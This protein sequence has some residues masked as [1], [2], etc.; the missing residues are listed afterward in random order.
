MDSL[1]PELLYR[2]CTLVAIGEERLA[3]YATISRAWQRMIEDRTFSH[4]SLVNDELHFFE[5]AVVNS[6]YKHRRMDIRRVDLSINL[7]S[8]DDHS[9]GR[10]ERQA[11]RNINDTAFSKAVTQLFGALASIDTGDRSGLID[12]HLQRFDSPMDPG[13]RGSEKLSADRLAMGIGH[14]KDLFELRYRD[15]YLQ[16]LKPENLPRLYNVASLTINGDNERKLAPSTVVGLISR[17][18][19]LLNVNC[20][21]WDNERRRPDQRR[22][23][24][25][26]LSEQLTTIPAPK[27]LKRFNMT[28]V[29]R[30][31]CNSN[32]L[33]ADIRGGIYA[34]N[35]DDLSNGLRL[36]SKAAPCLTNFILSGPIS[37]GPDIFRPLD[38]RSSDIEKCWEHLESFTIK[39]SAVRPDGGW[40]I[41]RAPQRDT[42]SSD[43]EG[44]DEEEEA[45]QED[46]DHHGTYSEDSLS[47][48]DSSDS[49]F[50]MDQLPPDSYGYEDERR[51]E[52]LNG[53]R[54]STSNF[55][56]KPTGELETLFL[57][58]ADAASRMPMLRYMS[59]SLE[60]RPSGRT[61]RRFR[62]L[63]FQYQAAKCPSN[64]FGGKGVPHLQ[65][66]VPRG[67]RMDE[68]LE[69]QWLL[70]LG[71]DGKVR[72][73]EW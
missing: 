45:E 55:R 35:A 7:P 40:Y 41:E 64:G 72:Y 43:A 67:W 24:R 4:L 25:S 2:I 29:N 48:Y 9:C 6:I 57:A 65:W 42:E 59:V 15:S 52:R 60:I 8:Y 10:F 37:V 19:N 70:L 46:E 51:D 69:S 39:L 61:G 28:F 20:V 68:Q 22:H 18:P 1:P 21:F 30:Q 49:F 50:A 56:T 38:T 32:F 31:P 23:L 13:R 63:G 53:D 14:R 5:S 54:P 12:L 44:E 3:K 33:D 34:A 71:N 16:L 27:G 36:F 26:Q 73:N 17:L 66:D 58:A 62:R 47:S 11:D